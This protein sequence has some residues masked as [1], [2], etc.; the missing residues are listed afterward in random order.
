MLQKSSDPYVLQK[1]T[2]LVSASM[3]YKKPVLMDTYASLLVESGN[4]DKAIEIEQ[5]IMAM[6][7]V[8]A[9]P[10]FSISDVMRSWISLTAENLQ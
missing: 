7:K 1:A 4:F 8:K 6:L 10:D 3:Q 5:Q 9:D 2:K